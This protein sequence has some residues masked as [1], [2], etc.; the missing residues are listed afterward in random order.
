VGTTETPEDTSPLFDDTV[1]FVVKTHAA[2][3]ALADAVMTRLRVP[4]A[5]ERLNKRHWPARSK[6]CAARPATARTRPL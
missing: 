3:R 2:S 1:S 4:G 6:L 5:I